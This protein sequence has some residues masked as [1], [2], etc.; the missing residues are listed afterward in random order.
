MKGKRRAVICDLQRNNIYPIPLSL[1][2]ILVSETP[3][4]FNELVESFGQENESVLIEYFNFLIDKEIIFFTNTPD[5]FPDM[6]DDWDEPYIITNCI[7]DLDDLTNLEQIRYSIGDLAIKSLQIRLYSNVSLSDLEEAVQVLK[8]VGLT[9]LELIIKY[10]I[11]FE[12]EAIRALL[13]RNTLISTVKIFDAP[14]D[15]FID[16]DRGRFGLVFYLTKSISSHKDCG[17]ISPEF[18]VINTKMYSESL[19]YNSCLNRKISIDVKGEIKNCPSMLKSY[20]NVENTH[21]KDVLEIPE[22]KSLW[23]LNKDK[24]DVCKDCEFRLIC[25]DCRAYIDD[26]ENLKS[27]PLKCGYNPYT[28]EWSDWST[29]PMKEAAAQYYELDHIVNV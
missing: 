15:Y 16:C 2:N 1:Y 17:V 7:I 4:T 21:L 9:S 13:D 26:P 6:P 27:K 29:N 22:F 12:D 3:Q 23:N 11:S 19:T 14:E 18:F 8:P 5:L 25:T 10:D 20:G 24:I 28:G